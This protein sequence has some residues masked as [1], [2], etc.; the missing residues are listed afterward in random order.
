MVNKSSGL[1]N[2][3]QNVT[4]YLQDIME[5]VLYKD[6]IN[7]IDARELIG[8]NGKK[9]TN[10]K[11]IATIN[12]AVKQK[13]RDEINAFLKPGQ[14]SQQLKRTHDAKRRLEGVRMPVQLPE[15]TL[16]K[17]VREIIGAVYFNEQVEDIFEHWDDWSFG[18][19]ELFTE[20][21]DDF[22]E[23]NSVWF[24]WLANALCLL[25]LGVGSRSRGI[26][27]VNEILPVTLGFGTEAQNESD[28]RDPNA[29]DESSL[30]IKQQF[31]CNDQQLITVRNLTKVKTF[32]TAKAKSF[33][34]QTREGGKD[35]QEMVDEA[36][37]F[38]QA[39]ERAKSLTKPFQYY[40]FDPLNWK[41]NESEGMEAQ[42]NRYAEPDVAKRSP[43]DVFFCLLREVRRLIEA[44]YK[45]YIAEH[46][47]E[48]PAKLIWKNSNTGTNLKK[49]TI[50]YTKNVQGGQ[51][52]TLKKFFKKYQVKMGKVV[53]QTFSH[54]YRDGGVD[55]F[56]GNPDRRTHELRRLYVCYSYQMFSASRMKE[57]AYAQRVLGHKSQMTSAFYTSI[58]IM[59]AFGTLEER[60]VMH[61]NAHNVQLKEQME[62][63]IQEEI[64]KYKRQLKE[65]IVHHNQQILNQNDLNFMNS[66]HDGEGNEGDD[67]GDDEGDYKHDDYDEEPRRKKQKT[68]EYVYLTSEYGDKVKMRKFKKMSGQKKTEREMI[69]RDK[70]ALYQMVEK[71]ATPNAA[72]LRKLGSTNQ[73]YYKVAVEEFKKEI[74]AKEEEEKQKDFEAI[75][76][77]AS[78][79]P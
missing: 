18:D 69:E 35:E 76:A 46:A 15:P 59:K 48:K 23:S 77:L 13:I 70:V 7:D 37:M 50:R 58:Q 61:G 62:N 34:Y 36:E 45:V 3:D 10:K 66:F 28:K 39:E 22:K 21:V 4:A 26:F 38:A 30:R 68:E 5:T 73:K 53:G 19:G 27:A 6:I 74:E 1:A 20:I 79:N 65:K 25:Q 63:I 47:S 29:K 54:L 51:S 72:N 55:E 41:K 49:Y 67:E 9:I 40:F 2:L 64:E 60:Y 42:E 78:M 56:K 14:K 71:G 44:L 75:K 17:S 24:D 12:G 52:K 8:G 11:T 32:E 31:A 33:L 57:M 16:W 43:R